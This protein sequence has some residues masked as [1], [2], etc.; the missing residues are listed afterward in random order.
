MPTVIDTV[1][2]SG[3]PERTEEVVVEE[4]KNMFFRVPTAYWNLSMYLKCTGISKVYSNVLEIRKC[5]V[6]VLE[7]RFGNKAVAKCNVIIVMS[8]L[9]TQS[10]LY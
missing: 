10:R 5:T 3:S 6:N 4:G 8:T 1:D 9:K 2:A 7:F